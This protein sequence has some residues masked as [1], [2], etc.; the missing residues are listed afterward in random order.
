MLMDGKSSELQTKLF[1]LIS[2]LH[3]LLRQVQESLKPHHLL[4]VPESCPPS[5]IFSIL[6]SEPR[7]LAAF[8]IQAGFIVRPI[9]PPT[10]PAGA[11]RIRVCLHAGNTIDEIEAL[12]KR[13]RKWVK[14]TQ[15]VKAKL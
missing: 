3:G 6:S 8:C 5:P 2:H 1:S 9:V 12:V 4:D 14:I 15:T 13:I 10:V 11:E 7:S